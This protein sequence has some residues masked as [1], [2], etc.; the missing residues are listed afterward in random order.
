MKHKYSFML[1]HARTPMS[2]FRYYVYVSAVQ[3]PAQRQRHK[4]ATIPP[5]HAY[6][7]QRIPIQSKT[8]KFC[9]RWLFFEKGVLKSKSRLHVKP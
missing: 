2:A 8:I 3:H 4:K 9:D 1:M 7:G 5:V 6:T